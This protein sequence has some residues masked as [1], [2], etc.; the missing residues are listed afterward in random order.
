MWYCQEVSKKINFHDICKLTAFWN[1]NL[2]NKS[3]NLE[4]THKTSGDGRGWVDELSIP[5]FST[6]TTTYI[7]IAPVREGNS[8][9][10]ASTHTR[11]DRLSI[12]QFNFIPFSCP[13]LPHSRMRA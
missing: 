4:Q 3:V 11:L 1:S 2:N 12:Q 10:E 9:E 8:G 7:A 6:N 5:F 13:A